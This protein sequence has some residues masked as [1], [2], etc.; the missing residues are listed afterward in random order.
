MNLPTCYPRDII[1][2][3]FLRGTGNYV[4]RE[5]GN[6]TPNPFTVK[7]P[8]HSRKLFEDCLVQRDT[9]VI[10]ESDRRIGGTVATVRLQAV[11]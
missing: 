8:G 5:F 9:H 11:P 2:G 3:S 4:S 1:P 7:T 6:S 10:R